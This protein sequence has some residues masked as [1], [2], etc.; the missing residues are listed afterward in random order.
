M[1]ENF[2]E[3]T[4]EECDSVL[5]INEKARSSS[6]ARSSF[7]W[8]RTRSMR[9]LRMLASSAEICVSSPSLSHIFLGE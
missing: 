4:E 9:S 1:A 5:R 7:A 3:A 8:F 6:T 2:D